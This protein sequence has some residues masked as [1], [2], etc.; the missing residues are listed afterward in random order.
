MTETSIFS[1]DSLLDEATTRLLSSE[2]LGEIRRILYGKPASPLH[3]PKPVYE[4]ASSANFSVESYKFDALPEIFRDPRIV[5]IGMVQHKIPLSPSSPFQDQLDAVHS[6][7]STITRAASLAGV[8]ILC[9]QVII[10]LSML[11]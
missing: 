10:L 11:D 4:I 7:I 1:I 8:N 2:E 5:R 6:K 3:L 9:Y